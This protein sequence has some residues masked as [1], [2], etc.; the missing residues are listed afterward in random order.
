MSSQK[1]GANNNN[2]KKTKKTNNDNNENENN[3]DEDSY[4]YKQDFM[5]GQKYQTPDDDNGIRV[6]YE[7]LYKQNA[8]SEMAIK[9]CLENGLLEE[10]EAIKYL[11]KISKKK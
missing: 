8:N 9:Y 1:K 4:D 11:K 10:E 5:P 6:F 3:D 2:S 7:T